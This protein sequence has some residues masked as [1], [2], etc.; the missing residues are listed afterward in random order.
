MKLCASEIKNKKDLREFIRFPWRIYQDYPRWIPPLWVEMRRKL[1]PKK[2]PFF[3]YGKVRLYGITN[4][5]REL[6]G[7]IAAIYNPV[8]CEIHHE[9]VGFFGLFET[10]NSIEVT[11]GLIGAVKTYL[12]EFECTHILGPVNFNTNDEA[13]LLIEGYDQSPMFMCDYS[14]PYYADLLAACGGEKA[15]DLISYGGTIDHS[16]PNKYLRVLQKVSSNSAIAVRPFDRRN[17]SQ[18]ISV[19]REIYNN[20]FGDVWGF[21]PLSLSETEE[22]GRNLISFSDGE[23]VWFAEYEKK[24]VGFILALPDVNEIL[25]DL[26]GHLFPLG[27]VRFL[28][29]RRHLK[30]V[31]VVVLCVLPSYRSTGIETLLIHQVCTRMK[32]GGYERAELSVVN[33]NNM[34]MRRILES[35]GFR[36]VKRYRIYRVPV[37]DCPP[38]N[39]RLAAGQRTTKAEEELHESSSDRTHSP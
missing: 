37:K 35:L 7:R 36:P 32:T 27:I 20:S 8:H 13:G 22:M 25:R 4:G 1:D 9:S 24:P 17:L 34:K 11:R 30:G 10:I 29:R 38:W 18:D 14:P 5:D 28:L 16:F 23:L 26:N 31:R 2:N 39:E 15:M 6:V 12:S 33:E 3:R 19:I 21:V